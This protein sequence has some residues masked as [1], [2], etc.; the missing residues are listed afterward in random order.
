MDNITETFTHRDRA[1]MN[2]IINTIHHTLRVAQGALE[3]NDFK[4]YKSALESAETMV[5]MLRM[6]YVSELLGE[7]K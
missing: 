7:G 4:N 3:E 6:G 1:Q 2:F 5:S